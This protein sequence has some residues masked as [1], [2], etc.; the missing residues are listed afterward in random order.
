MIEALKT[1]HIIVH[2]IIGIQ[3]VKGATLIH[4]HQGVKKR[5]FE[6]KISLICGHRTLH[7]FSYLLAFL[8]VNCLNNTELVFQY[9]ENCQREWFL[10]DT[11]L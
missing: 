4:E 2:Q 8:H 10:P 6:F 1:Y 7:Q 3:T 11:N 9:N 5:D